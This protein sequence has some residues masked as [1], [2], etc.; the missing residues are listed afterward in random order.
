M[1]NTQ[2]DISHNRQSTRHKKKVQQSNR[3]L[4]AAIILIVGGLSAI[5]WMSAKTATPRETTN[6]YG[7]PALAQ[8]GGTVTDFTIGSLNNGQ[9]SLA[10]YEGDVIIM[11]FWATWC[12][13]CRAEMPAIDRFYEAYKD[14]GL[15]VLA[16]N[17]EE[18]EETV[19][20]FIQ[21]N[22]FSFPVLLDTEGR[23]AQQYS[24]RSFPTTFIIDRQ[25]VIQHVQTGEIS[26]AE[27]E[28]I[29]KPLLQ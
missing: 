14:E 4:A 24:T 22:N 29:V 5:F 26:E 28:R 1:S 7:A 25:G 27:L 6:A 17:E 16:I 11:N 3:L 21:A 12:P 13:P 9:I 23:V 10:D 15:V 20:P 2:H 18:S 8:K 19:R